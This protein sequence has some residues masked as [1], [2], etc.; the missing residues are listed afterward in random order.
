[1]WL[2]KVLTILAVIEALT[3]FYV[4]YRIDKYEKEKTH[5][6]LDNLNGHILDSMNNSLKSLAYDLMRNAAVVR[7]NGLYLTPDMLDDYLQRGN[8]NSLQKKGTN[9]FMLNIS[10][11]ELH[12]FEI[13]MQKYHDP[14]FYVKKS[15]RGPEPVEIKKYYLVPTYVRPD[16]VK[17]KI[18]YSVD[19]TA[20]ISNKYLNN[21]ETGII[22]R[23]RTVTHPRAED[24]TPNSHRIAYVYPIY[25]N[26]THPKKW[27]VYGYTTSSIQ[28]EYVMR[29]S[30]L[31]VTYI[32]EKEIEA[33]ENVK[34]HGVYDIIWM[35]IQMPK[36]NGY[37]CVEK[38]REELKYKGIIIGLTGFVDQESIDLCHSYG[39]D[40]VIGKPINRHLF[41]SYIDSYCKEK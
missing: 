5:D 31:Q 15:S 24:Q 32:D 16:D 13:Y 33:I 29:D 3:T 35:D 23:Y 18:G 8:L 41:Y 12:A 28:L 11:E 10:Y 14:D 27:D 26:I 17:Y 1:M 21:N 34:Q 6:A 22:I 2:L 25:R 20:L 39:M 30:I 40:H 7:N 9:V 4:Y 37:K 36:M 38:L 19:V